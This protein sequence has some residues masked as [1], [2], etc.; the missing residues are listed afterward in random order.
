MLFEY[1]VNIIIKQNKNFFNPFANSTIMQNYVLLCL[2]VGT[3]N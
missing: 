3:L 2:R 1:I